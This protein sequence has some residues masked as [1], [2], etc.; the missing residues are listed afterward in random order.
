MSLSKSTSHHSKLTKQ[1]ITERM[2]RGQMIPSQQTDSSSLTGEQVEKI[3]TEP[4]LFSQLEGQT[5]TNNLGA[6]QT[7]LLTRLDLIPPSAI[8][9]IGKILNKG[10]AKYGVDNWRGIHATDNMNHSITHAYKAL[11]LVRLNAPT[12]EVTLELAQYACRAL[13]TLSVWLDGVEKQP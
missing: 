2:E 11:E 13:F 1:Q 3:E 5:V 8:L 10:A 7:A 6:K 4:S 9:E 12:D